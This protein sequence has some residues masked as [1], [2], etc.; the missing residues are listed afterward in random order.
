MWYLVGVRNHT[1]FCL[2]DD[3]AVISGAALRHRM[4]I[5]SIIARKEIM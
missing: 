3:N 5:A 1:G 4:K 2:A